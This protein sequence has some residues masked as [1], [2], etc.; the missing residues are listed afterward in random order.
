MEKEQSE[1][2]NNCVRM[3]K[4]A[5]KMKDPLTIN[6]GCSLYVL[7]KSPFKLPKLWK[8][9]PRINFV[10]GHINCTPHW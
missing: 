8:Q 10:Q 6:G 1:V 3:D 2:H 4:N 5:E 7:V 9:P